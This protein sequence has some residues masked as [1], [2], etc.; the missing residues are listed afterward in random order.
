ME[1]A[2][3]EFVYQ[4]EGHWTELGRLQEVKFF[5]KLEHKILQE[6]GEMLVLK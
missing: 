5:K 2:F 1:N 4:G 3:E 6:G